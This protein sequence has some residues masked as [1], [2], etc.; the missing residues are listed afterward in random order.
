MRKI[1]YILPIIFLISI[2]F[3]N[4]HA[5][6]KCEHKVKKLHDALIA[7]SQ[8]EQKFKERIFLTLRDINSVIFDSRKMIRIILEE[9]GKNLKKIKKKNFN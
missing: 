3:L 8:S 6:E 7:N 2:N 1:S 5:S 4:I 9:N